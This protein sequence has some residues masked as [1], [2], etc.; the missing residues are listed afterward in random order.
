MV[1]CTVL[2]WLR[3]SR[4][5]RHFSPV[6]YG[7]KVHWTHTYVVRREP[8]IATWSRLG[9]A[10]QSHV[11]KAGPLS[12]AAALSSQLLLYQNGKEQSGS[13]KW[14]SRTRCPYNH[15][16]HSSPANQHRPNARTLAPAGSHHFITSLSD[17]VDCVCFCP[18]CPR[19]SA[20]LLSIESTFV[21]SPLQS[22]AKLARHFSQGCVL[23]LS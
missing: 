7:G 22:S 14:Q 1:V 4:F 20:P 18:V 5:R 11:I 12:C 16:V 10:G 17:C 15:R 19:F 23:R 3:V 21:F 9:A 13:A 8:P 2:K 6:P